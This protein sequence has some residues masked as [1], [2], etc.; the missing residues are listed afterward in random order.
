MRKLIIGAAAM[1][2]VALPGVAAAQTTAT[3]G[4]S[5]ANYD[6]ESDDVDMFG[7][8]GAFAHD[9]SNGWTVQ[10]EAAHDR[11]DFDGAE[12]GVSYGAVNFG[13]RNEN[14]ALYGFVGLS[15]FYVS[16]VATVGVGGQLHFEQ[17]SVNGSVAYAD[18]G[19]A[20]IDSGNLTNVHVDGT[21]FITD[22]FGITG[23]AAWTEVE[24]DSSDTDWTTLGIGASYRFTDTP[25]TVYAGYQNRDF[26]GGDIDSFRIGVRFDIGS[27]SARE[28]ARSGASWNGARSL[29]EE[30]RALSTVL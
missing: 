20:F 11:I 1:L 2:A 23:E 9:F 16:S 18:I 7:L 8:D 4:V 19:E 3:L 24:V 27:G 5:Y 22:N 26:E 28:Q 29:Y 30:T 17:A 10:G 21:W 15:D 12:V 13:M 25:W 6:V 14:H